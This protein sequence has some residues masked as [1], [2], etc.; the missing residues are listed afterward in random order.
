[1]AGL[2]PAIHALLHFL[3]GK[4]WMPGTRPG[5]TAEIDALSIDGLPKFLQCTRAFSS[6]R[7]GCAD[8][9]IT[10]S[11]LRAFARSSVASPEGGGA[12]ERRRSHW[13]P[14]EGARL[15][16]DRQARLP[17]LHRGDFS[18]GHRAS[19][20]GP[21]G[22]PLTP[23]SRHLRRLSSARVQPSKAGPSTGPDGDR[24][25][26]DEGANPACRRRHPRSANMT[27][28]ESALS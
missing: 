7:D 12:P 18:R 27:P 24:A 14:H 3:Q 9:Q 22:L 25:S 6:P 16:C 10:L 4:A 26:W 19:S 5:M 11:L 8:C 13:A 20:S 15:P 23:S 1:M 2:V 21:E 28:H 17:A